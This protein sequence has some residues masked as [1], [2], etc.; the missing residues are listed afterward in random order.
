MSKLLLIV[1]LIAG[2]CFGYRGYLCL[3]L[4]SPNREMDSKFVFN[5]EL[6]IS[7][8]DEEVEKLVLKMEDA[9]YDI[10]FR[11]DFKDYETRENAFVRYVNDEVSSSIIYGAGPQ[12]IN[13]LASKELL[14]D[15]S[16]DQ[17]FTEEDRISF[18]EE[19]N[20]NDDIELL[21]YL[22]NNYYFE[23][24]IF[25]PSKKIKRNYM[26]NELVSVGY[27]TFESITLIKGSYHGYIFNIND[28]IREV[29][30]LKDDYQY[31][32]SLIGNDLMLDEYVIGLISTIDFVEK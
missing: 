7:N 22:K 16:D 19:N 30:L 26:L 18:L 27:P 29:H 12:Y 17:I 1:F 14:I 3:S 24:T 15:G 9:P 31:Y 25:T 13:L 28:H 32:F 20:I 21:D 11:N 5:R 10:S 8:S 23:S 4:D 6:I 2:I